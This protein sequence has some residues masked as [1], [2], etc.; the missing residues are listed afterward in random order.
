MESNEFLAAKTNSEY[1]ASPAF[2]QEVIA[3]LLVKGSTMEEAYNLTQTQRR[4][5]FQATKLGLMP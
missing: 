3:V 1:L 5:I 2:R 4:L